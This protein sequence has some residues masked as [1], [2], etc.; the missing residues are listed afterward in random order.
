[1]GTSSYLG[2][3]YP[4]KVA[5]FLDTPAPPVPHASIHPTKNPPACLP[6]PPKEGPS[7]VSGTQLA[8]AGRPTSVCSQGRVRSDAIHGTPLTC[9]ARCGPPPPPPPPRGLGSVCGG[10]GGC[11]TVV[12]PTIPRPPSAT[13]LERATIIGNGSSALASHG[14]EDRLLSVT[15]FPPPHPPT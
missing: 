6:P 8:P 2:A 11:T 3:T 14:G 4:K 15:A 13:P 12:E 9:H 5:V 7:D 10:G 1:M